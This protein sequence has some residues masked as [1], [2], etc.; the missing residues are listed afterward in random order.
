MLGPGEWHL[1]HI[2]CQYDSKYTNRKQYHW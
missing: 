1:L 2:I